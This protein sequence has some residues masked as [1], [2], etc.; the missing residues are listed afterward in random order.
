MELFLL[1]LNFGRLTL[2]PELALI[3]LQI[4]LIGFAR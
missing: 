2:S 3:S 4:C 1:S